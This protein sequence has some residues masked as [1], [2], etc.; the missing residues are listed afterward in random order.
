MTTTR[1]VWLVEDEA[2]NVTEYRPR[3]G[4][5]QLLRD[6]SNGRPGVEPRFATESVHLFDQL[7][8]QGG[9]ESMARLRRGRLAAHGVLDDAIADLERLGLVTRERPRA[10]SRSS[11]AWGASSSETIRLTE[12]AAGLCLLSNW[13]RV[14]G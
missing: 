13:S 2:G 5:R 11:R 6:A 4:P 9:E 8:R 3:R 14:R 1:E 12:K 7:E 10:S